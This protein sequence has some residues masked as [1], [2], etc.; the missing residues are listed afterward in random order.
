MTIIE[1]LHP[2]SNSE[3]AELITA[4]ANDGEKL[5]VR[6]GGSKDAI[7]AAT[8]TARTLD[9]SGFSGVVDYDPPELVLT[10]RAGTPLA[11]IKALLAAE[12]QML[13]F[14][15]WDHGP[16]LGESIGAAT[17]GGVTS[18]GVSGPRRLIS[19]AARDHLLGFE[20]VS[21]G[22]E[23]FKAGAKVV[24]NVTGFDLSKLIAGS[25]GRL[26][27]M[28]ELTLKVVPKPRTRKTLL[29]R[30]LDPE[31][32]VAMMARALG[33][34][35]DVSAT[36]HLQSWRDA[37]ATVFRLDGFP[38][39]VA[40]RI[41]TLTALIGDKFALESLDDD[42]SDALWDEI[43]DVTILPR[44][45]P[46][47]RIVVAPS[48]APA[49]VAALSDTKWFMD[50]AGGL[51]WAATAEDATKVRTA[52]ADSGGHATLIRADAA[53][54]AAIS[55]FHPQASGVEALETQVR[56]AFDPAGVFETG[57]F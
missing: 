57:R 11:E 49:F 22:G 10:A 18:A 15:P 36:T 19:G 43:R 23:I 56:R 53:V 34:A 24:K 55:T 8:P 32:A 47:W 4:A 21:G 17:I 27:A 14:D 41:D 7:G 3:L 33:S 25:W 1:E 30:G 2:A 12:Q 29:L 39:S 54:R 9:M 38:P 6:G 40:A 16:M 48:K 28:T 51:V 5:R 52:A 45:G 20:A 13:A 37:P 35:A 31:A 26:V 44:N 46:L 42:A 50:W